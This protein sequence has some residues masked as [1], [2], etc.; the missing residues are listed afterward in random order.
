MKLLTTALGSYLTGDEIAHAVLEYG[1]AL[2]Q[3]QRMDLV[4]IPVIVDE[5]TTRLRFAVGWSVQLHVLGIQHDGAEL[6]DREAVKSLRA[7]IASC[8]AEGSDEA[9]W[10]EPWVPAG[11]WFDY[12]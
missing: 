2:A 3:N 9:R 11:D 6:L 10:V 7:R 12:E 1:H 4:D 5:I 8:Q